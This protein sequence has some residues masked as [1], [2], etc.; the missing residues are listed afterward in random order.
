MSPARLRKP[1]L[2]R[3]CA[4]AFS[5]RTLDSGGSTTEQLVPLGRYRSTCM[6]LCPT[7][8]AL[9]QSG[10]LAKPEVPQ[11]PKQIKHAHKL[12]Q[13]ACGGRGG[14]SLHEV[15]LDETM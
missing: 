4:S 5:S 11:E 1:R 15:S 12:V 10:G 14:H 2:K 13:A 6:A 7:G 9:S 3:R 8:Q